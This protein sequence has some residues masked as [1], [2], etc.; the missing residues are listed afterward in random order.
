MKSKQEVEMD[1]W[2]EDLS[3]SRE[4]RADRVRAQARG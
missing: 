3:A 4:K 2:R 1:V